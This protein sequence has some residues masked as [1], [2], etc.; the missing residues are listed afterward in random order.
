VEGDPV[1]RV[2]DHA[3]EVLMNFLLAKDSSTLQSSRSMCSRPPVVEAGKR[4][5]VA[6]VHPFLGLLLL[7]D[8]RLLGL[9]LTR[10]WVSALWRQL[11]P[12]IGAGALL[13]VVTGLLLF[14]SDPVRFYGNV[15]F[16]IKLVALVLAAL[17]AAVYHLGIERRLVEWDTATPP[18]AAK[19]AGASS[20]AIWVIVVV[21]GRLIAYNWFP[22]LV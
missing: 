4:R 14:W 5:Q 12:W 1:T 22:S 17:N 13:I 20:I 10:V 16:R 19:I 3:P 9:V 21:V 2:G 18:R 11:F 7:W 6:H 15:F 8:T